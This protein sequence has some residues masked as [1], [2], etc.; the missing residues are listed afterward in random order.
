MRKHRTDSHAD[1]ST[2]Q[3]AWAAGALLIGALPHMIAVL[4]WV[5][6]LVLLAAAWRIAIA[7]RGWKLPPAWIRIPL[8]L[9]GFLAVAFSYRS[10]SGVEAGSALLM[11]M[12]AMKLLELRGQ[13]DRMVLI[14]IALF[15]LFA[16][17]LREQSISRLGW[18]AGGT[19]GISA[20]LVQTTRREELLPPLQALR[21]TGKL[22]LQGLPLALVLFVLFPRIPGPFWSLPDDSSSGITGLSEEIRP[23]DISSL[24][25]S[26]EVVFRAR[27]PAEVPPPQALYWRALVLE[28]FDG[29]G[30]SALRSASAA[31]APSAATGTAY[32]YEL[33][34]E[35]QGRRWLFGLETP[36]AWSAPGARLGAAMELLSPEPYHE[37]RRYQGR[38]VTSGRVAAEL[39]PATLQASLQFPFG[40][41]PRS[42][43]L[44]T[45]LRDA[46]ANDRDYVQRILR[47]FREEAFH[48]SLEPPRLGNQPVDEF[49]FEARSGFCEH[50]ASAMALLARAAGI[51]ARVVIGYQG[52]EHN[53]IGDYWIVRQAHAHA[54]VELQLDGAWERVDPTAAIAP[55]RVQQGMTDALARATGRNPRLWRSSRLLG[56][57]VLSWDAVNAAWDRWVLAFGPETQAQLLRSLGFSTPELSHLAL[58]ASLGA[59][60]CLLGLA[61]FAHRRRRRSPDPLPRLYALF[62]ERLARASGHPRQPGETPSAYASAIAGRR[63]DL[64]DEVHTMTEQ[65]LRL[66]YGGMASPAAI[67]Q[68]KRQLHRFRPVRK[69][70]APAPR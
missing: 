2:V 47:M 42:L 4:P 54:W 24:A 22:L 67:A 63:P 14:F 32:D 56:R 43:T 12:G 52:A 26:D 57:V 69:A 65:Y 20:A 1:S 29:R 33:V 61:W 11:V 6:L 13:R 28:H 5:S 48:Y 34:L 31:P 55:E 25:L 16:V 15:L 7:L 39:S 23:G 45:T 36:V 35:P 49:L 62:C 68:F 27:F 30:W 70:A 9:A 59:G 21:L 66:R 19:L 41:N 37:R 8:A 44:A 58:L 3:V 51:P 53:P 60:L 50:Y 38:S 40:R 17:F 64:A 18:L 10:I 46:S